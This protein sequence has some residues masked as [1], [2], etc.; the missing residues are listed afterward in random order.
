MLSGEVP[1]L[2]DR[3]DPAGGGDKPHSSPLVLDL[4]LWQTGA[5]TLQVLAVCM[6]RRDGGPW[7][8]VLSGSSFALT[9]ASALW[10][11]TLPRLERPVRNAAVACLGVTTFLQWRVADPLVFTGYDE[12]M[13]LRT[14][15]DIVLSQ[16]LF[17]PNPILDVSPRYPGL[18]AVATLFHQMGLPVTVAAMAVVLV[19]RLALVLVLCDAVENLTGS[20][21]AGGLAV[22]GYAVCTQ[23]VGFNSQFAYQSLALPLALA[24]VALLARARRAAEPAP[25]LG[26]AALCLVAVAVTHHV[27]SVLTA[28]FL[29]VWTIAEGEAQPKRRLVF[30]AAIAAG[31]TT[32]WAAIQWSLLRDYFAPIADDLVSQVTNGLHRTPFSESSGYREPVWMRVLEIYYA[33]AVTA[34]VAL[35]LVIWARSLVLRSRPRVLRG[36][37]PE[38]KPAGL[39]I[40]LV[41]LIPALMAA[42]VLPSGSEIDGRS[43]SFLFLPFGLLVAEGAVR[44]W[45]YWR[46]R[47]PRV[48]SN[49]GFIRP[50]VLVLATGVFLGGYLMGSGPD[51]VRLPGKYAAASNR[52]MDAETLKAVGWAHDELPAG[53]RIGA[54]F[55]SAL[56]LAS[57]AG[58]WPVIQEGGLDVS[59]LYFDD[60]WDTSQTELVHRLNLRYLYVDQRLADDLPREGRYF[61]RGETPLPRKLSH[62]QLTK[63]AHVPGIRVVYRDGPVTIY[64]LGGL[65]VPAIQDGWHGPTPPRPT[66]LIQLVV[67][68][69]GGLVVATMVRPGWIVNHAAQRFRSAAGPSLT[70]AAVV[71]SLCVASVMLLMSGIWLGAPVLLTMVAVVIVV[72]PSAAAWRFRALV[73]RLDLRYLA[74][75]ALLLP[76][77]AG[78]AMATAASPSAAAAPGLAA[79]LLSWWIELSRSW[80]WQLE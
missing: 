18:E 62:A 41:A 6:A 16:S 51:I 11:L 1:R 71:A 77:S 66:V 79:T 13:H 45:N 50:M 69:V 24:A 29:V 37:R 54:D 4:L 73:A 10:F 57:Q 60:D 21:R 20:A 19:A 39:L 34:M 17:E 14:L 28:V 80:S 38:W 40:I 43:N 70:F 64:D 31:A 15:R 22:A 75:L 7:P 65:G 47:R 44:G 49:L 33:V 78:I 76:I 27:T 5:L 46:R 25:L 68:L 58:M 2:H 3:A 32:V 67:G 9:F 72:N 59:A 23:F 35:L 12:Q 42:R 61:F 52:A 53:S 8:Y 26:G 55:V 63:F 36:N 30:G 56:L 74:M 48:I